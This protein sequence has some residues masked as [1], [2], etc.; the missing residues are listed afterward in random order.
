MFYYKQLIAGTE[1][2]HYTETF[3]IYDDVA[4][5]AN[6]YSTSEFLDSGYAA[7]ITENTQSTGKAPAIMV[8]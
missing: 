4:N 8:Y 1:V 6:V 7:E 5:S 3:G 2:Q